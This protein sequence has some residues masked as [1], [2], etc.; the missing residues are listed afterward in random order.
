M[1]QAGVRL[2]D[3]WASKN[4]GIVVADPTIGGGTRSIGRHIREIRKS[5]MSKKYRLGR[6]RNRTQPWTTDWKV[7]TTLQEINN[8]GGHNTFGKEKIRTRKSDPGKETAWAGK[9]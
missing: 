8:M 3:A 1:Q 2:L 4:R 9:P 7:S 6:N 5:E